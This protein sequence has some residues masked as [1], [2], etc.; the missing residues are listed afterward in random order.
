[1]FQ[2]FLQEKLLEFEDGCAIRKGSWE[3][4]YTELIAGG[5]S[6]AAAILGQ[7]LPKESVVALVFDTKEAYILSIIGV[8]NARCCF[9][10]VDPAL[11]DERIRQILGSVECA[12][13][14]C[15]AANRDRMASLSTQRPCPILDIQA[16]RSGVTAEW[17]RPPENDYGPEDR[18]YIYFTS[19]TSG[20]PKAIVG[21]N[22]SLLHYIQWEIE[23][24]SLQS[25]YQY[26]Q[27]IHVGFDAFLR[28][29]FVPLCSGGTINLLPEATTGRDAGK[30]VSWIDEH[31]I[32]V[33][34]CV[35]GLFRL[36][37]D[38]LAGDRL[39]SIRYIFLSGEPI[40]P[41]ELAKWYRR[42]G[43]DTELVN[44]YGPTETTMTKTFYRIRESDAR[45][46]KIP[47]GK[48]MKGCRVLL[49]DDG[50]RPCNTL[51]EGE[52]YIR[53][54]FM[55]HGYY[56]VEQNKD[57]F[58]PNPYS[59]NPADLLYRTGDLG[60][61]LPDG[62][63]EL[64][65]RVD[66]QIKIRGVRI[67]PEEIED[68]LRRHPLIDEA[69]LIKKRL[70]ENE[71]DLLVCFFTC[72]EKVGY[73]GDDLASELKSFL[74]SLLPAAMVPAELI[75]MT[76]IQRLPNGKIDYR[77]LENEYDRKAKAFVLPENPLQ[78]KILAIWKE[79]FGLKRI[80]VSASFIEIGGN[81]LNIFQLINRL[82][83][84]LGVKIS[85]QDVFRNMTIQT[86]AELIARGSKGAFGVVKRVEERSW[87][88]LT[89]IQRRIYFL[90]E[91]DKTSLAYNIPMAFLVKG[92]VSMA[93]VDLVCRALMERHESLRTIFV[94]AETMPI[95][96]ICE[97]MPFAVEYFQANRDN[98]DD[99]I[100]RFIRPFALD[101]GPLFRVGIIEIGLCEHVLVVDISHI[102]CD[103]I[104][105]GLLIRDFFTLY[106]GREL[107]AVSFRYRDL[108]GWK[109]AGERIERLAEHR[110][111]WM[112]EFEGELPVMTLP[113]DH[114]RPAI[115]DHAG[116]SYLFELDEQLVQGIRALSQVENCS[117]YIV[118]LAAFY[119]WLSKLSGQDDLIV[120][121]PVADRPHADLEG[122][123]GMFA[124]TLALRVRIEEESSF[125]N[126]VR[127]VK[128]STLEAFDHR[129][130]PYDR[131]VDDVQLV[132]DNSR[133][134]LFD[135]LFVF[136]NAEK[137]IDKPGEATWERYEFGHRAAK[138]DLTLV[139][140]EQDKRVLCRIEYR[141]GLFREG[142]IVRFSEYFLNLL[143]GVV[144]DADKKVSELELLS[145]WDR[146]RIVGVFNDTEREYPKHETIHGMF[147]QEVRRGPD[148]IA[149]LFEDQYVSYGELDR[150]SDRVAVRLQDE[151]V[152]PEGL[153]GIM[154]DRSA[155]MMAGI[156]GVLKAG[157]AYVPL[158]PGYPGNRINFMIRDSGIVLMLV[159]GKYLGRSEGLCREIAI[160]E[161]MTSNTGAK[162][163]P[164]PV[165]G[166][167]LA[168]V[169]Y[170]SG[171][172][173]EPKGVQIEH[174]SVVNRIL[175][176]QRSY[177]ID[178]RDTLL[179]KTP[180]N[181]DVSVWELF[182]W[183]FGG[184]RLVMLGGGLEKDPQ[185]LREVI[186]REQVSVIHFV[187]SMLQAF[188]G[189]LPA[190]DA[191][192]ELKSLRQVFC[193]G[194]AL[195]AGLVAVFRMRINRVL[196]ARLTNLY[197]PTE[198]TVDVSYYNCF[199][200]EEAAA[201]PIGR[202][203]DN[204]ALYILDK[205]GRIVPEGVTGEI[206]IAGVG[207]ARGYLNRSALTEE[208][209]T[210][211]PLVAGGR[212]Y[213]TGDLGRW[214]QDGNIEYLG[215]MDQQ[216]KIR[217]YRIEPGEIGYQMLKR[218][219]VREAVVLARRNARA[220]M[221]LAAYYISATEISP[222]EWR[223]HLSKLLPDYMIPHDFM[224]LERIPVTANGKLDRGALPEPAPQG[225]ASYREPEN[226]VEAGLYEIWKEVLG[227]R[228]F[229]ITDNFF[230][231]GGD[232]LKAITVVNRVAK[233]FGVQIPLRAFM[234]NPV[235]KKISSLIPGQRVVKTGLPHASKKEYYNLSLNQERLYVLQSLFPDS[236]A[237]NIPIA[238][239]FKG[240]IDLDKIKRTVEALIARH[241][242][243]RT[244][245]GR[246]EGNAVQLIHD[247]VCFDIGYD[248]TEED[249]HLTI[250]RQHIQP[251]DPA[252][253]PLFRVNV[254]KLPS[255]DHLLIADFHHIIT[256]EVSQHIFYEEFVGIYNGGQPPAPEFQYK[257]FS[258]WQNTFIR[259]RKYLECREYWLSVYSGDLPNLDLPLD[260][261]R[262]K[263][264]RFE[265]AMVVETIDGELKKDIDLLLK[266]QQVTLYVLL[267][268][269]A[270]I[271]LAKYTG[272]DDIIIGTDIAGRPNTDCES[273]IGFFIGQ[274]PV[275]NR[276]HPEKRIT[277]LLQEV[278]G[279]VVDAM[280]YQHYQ[281]NQLVKELGLA[282]KFDQNPLFNVSLLIKGMQ[283][284][285]ENI[286]TATLGD[287]SR[288]SP[289]HARAY[290]L[291]AIRD[292]Q[293]N[294]IETQDGLRIELVYN[295]SLFMKDTCAAMLRRFMEI[296]LQ[297]LERG[298]G[299]IADL[300]LSSDFER[301]PSARP[302]ASTDFAF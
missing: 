51:V 225:R 249:D 45:L 34:H 240:K 247:E 151:G 35:P 197:G 232:S 86:Q 1:M 119:C 43:E 40:A 3:M 245:F 85:L 6:V 210:A 134:P 282:G 77:E 117:F 284:S 271:L 255:D 106:N 233:R 222:E 93:K 47:V 126:F 94:M 267:L 264:Q 234:L 28:D 120:G 39:K 102:V 170:T 265:G 199:E 212:I 22:K 2:M 216:V 80:S 73:A 298:D 81:S 202:P 257:D 161:M 182:W 251:F 152:G 74:A 193:S 98:L 113:A 198:A 97:E 17:P 171:S 173:G 131:L 157:G 96:R 66:R 30:L 132:R 237:Y 103:K 53:T 259:S 220:E 289:I 275:R 228:R 219:G 159:S 9:M 27:F 140:A 279:H 166:N 191:V 158:D 139:A 12:L 59:T 168:Y 172:T 111:Y 276:P 110:A 189:S 92:G 156:L 67:E 31:N 114:A 70:E 55:T 250:I 10:P 25:G 235:I 190:R 144:E 122:L 115:L 211:H 164:S 104:S 293:F 128:K 149:V 13:L 280:Q 203:I 187:P 38:D 223:D 5:R 277:D 229:G 84:S 62:N 63:L 147:Q 236:T 188:M 270:N 253:A 7:Q 239:L 24:F 285:S 16:I 90:H 116:S 76:A 99:H 138:F 125:R 137:G 69:V 75:E 36:F 246:I 299:R 68:T 186:A 49:L 145:A 26:S 54:P 48:P 301:L 141:T 217:G 297:V 215:R 135:V 291:R 41:S 8:L 266:E 300:R 127:R 258:E 146:Q 37:N 196:G 195:S 105:I 200:G 109:L 60:K 243:L 50:L 83:K 112:K 274:L 33:I 244:S 290:H 174:H 179:Q 273:I 87:Y 287:G 155:E 176:M 136:E 148:R 56:D 160:E 252:I 121:T 15:D 101:S 118:L 192:R 256:D 294:V 100:R 194:E 295:T 254:V 42:R 61:F 262:P 21:K 183:F 241:E 248:E 143:A 302:A 108:L 107:P 91:L 214:R 281:Y 65:G 20:R 206:C 296:L 58:I 178:G 288:I 78:E 4:S 286:Q 57:K 177:R 19:G 238:F 44:L 123:V 95:Q 162:P 272:Q 150:L 263:I 208:K 278:K 268:A 242:I 230:V 52:I 201:V 163:K 213:R 180:Y 153:V 32:N 269:V 169:I 175:W 124:N 283:L 184:S 64:C 46:K 165:A 221:E 18:I 88:P 133:N 29:V 226:E 14:I 89:F 130:Y 167:G 231:L 227:I 71:E 292:L 218:G 224:R 11:P 142:T 82:K 205:T 154:I 261:P 260:L 181:F 204:I 79:V 185:A 72:P 209:F 207:L 23:T 129:D